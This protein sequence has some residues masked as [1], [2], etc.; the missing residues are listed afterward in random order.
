MSASVAYCFDAGFARYAAVATYSAHVNGNVESIYW[1]VAEAD[2]PAASLLQRHMTQL[3]VPVHLLS[4]GNVFAG[5][6]SS[7]H[8]SPAMYLRLLLP[9]LLQQE[10]RVIYLD[11]D[12]L[13]L[14]PLDDLAGFD[15]GS[16]ILAGVC[17]PVGEADTKIVRAAGDKYVNS[18]VLLMDLEKLREDGV[19]GKCQTLYAQYKDQLVWPDQCLLNK[20]AEGR[21][22]CL[23]EKWNRQIFTQSMKTADWQQASEASGVVHFVGPI[24]PWQDWCHPD[25]AEFWWGYAGKLGLKDF[26]PVQ[27][28]SLGQARALTKILDYNERFREASLVKERIIQA[29]LDQNQQMESV[30]R[31]RR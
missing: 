17:D 31:S 14:A 30:L 6:K 28:S 3:G 20:Y 27:I 19:L 12:T 2:M 16:A 9:E 13:V 29:L 24:K 25:I 4:A 21:K 10:R 11:C 1:V 8:F 23:E 7:N 18:G 22:A 5:W 26:G 15:L